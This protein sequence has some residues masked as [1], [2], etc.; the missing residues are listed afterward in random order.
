LTLSTIENHVC[1]LYADKQPLDIY[2]YISQNDIDFILSEPEAH[3]KEVSL[4]N[5][6][7]KWN[8]AFT[9]FQ[10]KLALTYLD[11]IKS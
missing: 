9:F 10:I 11:L 3:L 6:F 2:Q 4:K 8:G 5:L 1:K 7:E